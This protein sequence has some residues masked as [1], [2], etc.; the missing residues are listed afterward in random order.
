MKNVIK[1]ILVFVCIVV[2]V[3][4]FTACESYIN[5]LSATINQTTC[6]LFGHS[7]VLEGHKDATCTGVGYSADGV[8]EICGFVESVGNPLSPLGHDWQEATETTPK[9]CARCG[10][11]E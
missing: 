2:L 1:M 4:N 6:D 11:T 10:E 3:M 8:C 9:T 7:I 5:T